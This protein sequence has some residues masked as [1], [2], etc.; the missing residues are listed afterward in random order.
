MPNRNFVVQY[1]IKAADKFSGVANKFSKSSAKM[2]AKVNSLSAS[3]KRTARNLEKFKLKLVNAGRS[4]RNFGAIATVGLTLPI[5]L[6][7]K[8]MITSA[9]NAE[10]ARSKFDTIFSKMTVKANKMAESLADGFNFSKIGAREALSFTGDILTGFGFTQEAA[11]K[12]SNQVQE[13]AADMGSLKNI[14]SKR[15]SEAITKALL[16][17]RESLKL[18][19]VAILDM[20]VK[21]R[22]ALMTSQGTR[23]ASLKEAKALATFQLITEQ[24][25]NSIGDLART[26]GSLTNRTKRLIS[27]YDDLKVQLGD[28]LLPLMLKLVNFAMKAVNA[29][30]ALSPTTQKIILIFAGVVAIAGPL[31][32][33]IGLLT[34][35]M[36]VLNI[37]TIKVA[38]ST[39]AAMAPYIAMGAAIMAVFFA[40]KML[41]DKLLEL[42]GFD[43]KL[44]NFGAGIANFFNDDQEFISRKELSLSGRSQTDVN[45]NVGLAGGLEQKGGASVVPKGR[46]TNVGLNAAGA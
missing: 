35:A 3:L 23:F 21:R 37:A 27:K 33:M 22:I 5:I 28:K 43:K 10:E 45:L 24:A 38:I 4:M 12:M 44:E 1:T 39:L 18:L 16:G 41:V 20:D 25:K 11:L 26:K 29:F 19:G 9:A 30:T 34:M 32:S 15:V 46:P 8:S 7:G 6:M 13:L 40:V 14:E 36:G 42:S 31:L 2:K 17:E